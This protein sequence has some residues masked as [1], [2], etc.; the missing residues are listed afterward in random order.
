MINVAP[1]QVYSVI[2]PGHVSVIG[3][4]LPGAETIAHFL[5]RSTN[6]NVNRL[7]TICVINGEPILRKEWATRIILTGD[8]VEFHSRPYGGGGNN[9][10]KSVLGIVALVALVAVAP[11]AAQTAWFGLGFTGLAPSMLSTAFVIGGGMLISTFL[12]PKPPTTPDSSNLGA[13]DQ[14]YSLTA[15]GNTSKLLSA[16]PCSY[17]KEKRFPDYASIPWAEYIGGDQYLNVLLSQGVG[18]FQNHQLFIDDTVLWDEDNGLSDS[19]Q[20]VE[21]QF[22]DPGEAVTLFPTNIVQSSEVSG[23]ELPNDTSWIGGFIVN[24]A[25]TSATAIAVD[26]GFPAGLYSINQDPNNG[27]GALLYRTASIAAQY[28][29]VNDAGA[30]IGPWMTL[31]TETRTLVARKPLRYSTKVDV[32]PGRYEV[33]VQRVSPGTT[34]PE[35]GADTL[36][37]LGLRAYL[38]GPTTFDKISVIA[39]RIKATAQLSQ[40]AA[41]KFGVIAT[42]ILNVWDSGA[43]MLVEEA[44][45]NPA[46]AFWDAATNTQY[47]ANRPASKV[48]FQAIVDLAASAE[49]RGDKFNYTFASA[50]A[51]P[52]AFDTILKVTRTKHRWIGDVL[53]VVRDEWKSV[54]QLLL[55]DKQIV[56]GTLDVEYVFN[57]EDNADSV[58]ME[59]LDEDI[60]GPAEVQY[61][62]NDV[63]FTSV[64]PFRMRMDGVTNRAHATREAA[65]F[66]YQNFYR[67]IKVNLDTEHDG[68]ILN[69]G[70]SIAVQSS[71]PQS[72]AISGFVEAYNPATRVLTMDQDVEWAPTCYVNIRTRAGKAF[73]PIK[74]TQGLAPNLA[75]LDATD[76]GIVET[77]LS[78]TA[79]EALERFDGQEPATFEFGTSDSFSRRCIVLGGRPNG[80]RVS[81]TLVVDVQDVHSTTLDAVPPLPTVPATANPSV[82]TISGLLANFVQGIAEPRLSVSWFPAPGA[83]S[84]VAQISNDS[85]A[86]WS[87][88]HDSVDA[89]FTAVM[90]YAPVRVRVQGVSVNGV[91]GPWTSVDVVPPTIQIQDTYLSPNVNAIIG[92]VRN[93]LAKRD[94]EIDQIA[95][96]I[97]SVAQEQDAQNFID[98]HNTKIVAVKNKRSLTAVINEVDTRLT[99]ELGD[100]I[101]DI[102][103]NEQTIA[104]LDTAFAAYQVTVSARFADN[105]SSIASNQTALTDLES[106]FGS[107]QVAVDARFDA[108]EAN[109][110]SNATAIADTNTALTSLS[111]TLDARLDTAEANISSNASAIA[112]ANTAISTIE[113][114]VVAQF[115]DVT[116]SVT[117]N[118]TAIAGIN[119]KMSAQWTVT[120][121]VNGYVSGIKSY[122]D[123]TTS[124]FTIVADYFRVAFPG[125]SGGAPRTIFGIANVDG[126]AKIVILGDMIADGTISVNKISAS[127]LSSISANIGTVTAGIIQNASGKM[128]INLNDGTIKGYT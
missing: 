99:S 78:M 25:G 24:N 89:Q 87:T 71:L 1:V 122:N 125:V 64:K 93:E 94:F 90:D 95:R 115:D 39:L 68:R 97:A 67:R 91:H 46:W 58:I 60:W 128:I 51:I 5:E 76:L 31:F 35:V 48:D 61:P 59:Y 107:Y 12:A 23:T 82:P 11:W 81:L 119:G 83:V 4:T 20:D 36:A 108:A 19:F 13:I 114:T 118:T 117:A 92:F 42:R 22:C 110:A 113:D 7:P 69:F 26:W 21:Y 120:L 103:T 47:G 17:G 116:A 57:D 3:N 16:I 10:L 62:P 14:V 98:K 126:V 124:S 33:R 6:F 101:A 77:Q 37:W 109:V 18:K 63:S 70:S 111:T 127:S 79:E 102:H 75:V 53:S 54:P 34:N 85:G 50:V 56:R 74:V 28:R 100:A 86:S 96:L 2:L 45:Q 38:E 104:D 27:Q 43:G 65:F 73:G 106:S 88:I 112:D 40:N 121:D 52:A 72:W 55:T 105:E 66:Y 123:G 41:K 29:L 32:L 44:T 30:P 84:Y 15:S 8:R 80:N 9:K 49:A